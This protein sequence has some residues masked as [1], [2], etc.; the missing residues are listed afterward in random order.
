MR[1]TSPLARILLAA[2]LL[3]VAPAG[4]SAPADN[5]VDLQLVLAVDVSG[6]MDG[7]EQRFQRQGYVAAFRHPD[8]LDAIRAGPLWPDR[9][10]LHGMVERNLPNG[11][12]TVAGDRQR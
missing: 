2:A 3:A 12:R 1:M 7:N 11:R 4:T 6:S 8:V 9:Y 5:H 10:R